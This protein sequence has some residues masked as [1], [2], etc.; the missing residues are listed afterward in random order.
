MNTF[1]KFTGRMLVRF[2]LLFLCSIFRNVG[3]N[4]LRI[5]ILQFLYIELCSVCGIV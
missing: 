4:L 5:E 2:H 3:I 1:W